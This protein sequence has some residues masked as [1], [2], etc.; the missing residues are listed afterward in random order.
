MDRDSVIPRVE[1]SFPLLGEVVP[2]DHGYALYG[3]M[4]RVLGP[5]LHGADWLSVLP[6]HGASHS[7][8]RLVLG[9]SATLRLR[10]EPARISDVIALAGRGLDLDGHAVRVG[11]PHVRG[12]GVSPSLAA[13]LV[14]IKGYLEPKSFHGAVSRQLALRGVA[15]RSVIGARRVVN[16]RGDCVV[17]F[18]VA[19][20]DLDER[21]SLL[22][23]STG[24]GGRQRFG[25]GVFAA[26]RAE[27][28]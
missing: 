13:R 2:V 21:A 20:H 3:A 17:G 4:S 14:V 6:I 11:V 23:Q 25:C 15:A 27:D 1:L 10:L 5:A 12:L 28:S 7:G 19:L 24:L 8:G 26:S 18:A 22:V 9:K 16:V